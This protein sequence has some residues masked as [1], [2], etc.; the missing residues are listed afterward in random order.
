MTAFFGRCFI[1][2]AAIPL[3]VLVDVAANERTASACGGCF[4][5]PMTSERTVVTGHRMVFSISTTQTVLWDQIQYSGDPRE[6]AWVLPVHPGATIELSRDEWFAALDASTQPLIS[7]PPPSFGGGG[8]SGGGGCGC[9][10]GDDDALAA[11]GGPGQG[12]VQVV[13]QAVVG[14]YETVTLRATDPK[15]LETWLA[16]HGFDLPAAIQPTIDAYVSEGFDFIALRLQPGQGVRAM[17]PVRVITPGADESLPLRMVAAGVGATVGVTLWVIGEGRYEAQNFPNATIDDAKL[18]WDPS[19]NRSNYEEL[20]TAAMALSDGR[21]WLTES[22]KS[23]SVARSNAPTPPGGSYFGNPGLAD[24]YYGQCMTTAPCV[25]TQS[26]D[27][28]TDADAADDGASDDASSEA[29][30]DADASAD[31]SSDGGD[32]GVCTPGNGPAI[33]PTFDDLALATNGL[34]AS[35]VWVT[36]LRAVLPVGALAAGDLRLQ[37]SSAQTPVS[38]LHVASNPPSPN[39]PASS[40]SSSCAAVARGGDDARL[41]TALL[42]LMSAI[43]TGSI[44]RRRK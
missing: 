8:G 10:G 13:T 27:A 36:R 5:E 6:F 43:V 22:A 20:S 12:Q 30:T 19:A 3:A 14:P 42:L 23:A 16:Q 21:T 29:A 17:K 39:A 9:G 32:S 15:A 37:A 4:H 41:G 40:D 1:A 18:V 35:S 24:A 33:C 25:T 38:N 34:H 2:I 7:A 31:A 26:L 11:A 28:G 44:L